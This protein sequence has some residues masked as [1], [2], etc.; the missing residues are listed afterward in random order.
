MRN[1]KKNILDKDQLHKKLFPELY[2]M[3]RTMTMRDHLS[4]HVSQQIAA[5][6]LSVHMSAIASTAKLSP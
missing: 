2:E 1:L 4:R 5:S 3:N 6:Q